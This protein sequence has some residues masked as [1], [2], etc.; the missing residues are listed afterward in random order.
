[1]D[2]YTT[3]KEGESAAFE[4][5]NGDYDSFRSR[6]Y[7]HSRKTGKTFKYHYSHPILTV[8]RL[9]DGTPRNRGKRK[10]WALLEQQKQRRLSDDQ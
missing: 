3:I 6:V 10:R 2:E 5:P 7:Y 4:F 9:P 8:T 1:M